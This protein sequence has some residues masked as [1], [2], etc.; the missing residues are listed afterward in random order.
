MEYLLLILSGLPGDIGFPGQNGRLG[1][2]GY[3]GPLGDRGRTG[4]VTG[5]MPAE[6]GEPGWKGPVGD[7]GRNGLPGLRGRKVQIYS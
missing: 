6:N 4:L 5:A 2:K 7:P 1:R 3:P